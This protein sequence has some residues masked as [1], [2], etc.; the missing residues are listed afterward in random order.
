MARFALGRLVITSNAC[1]L[2]NRIDVSRCLIRH[3][4]GDWGELC[5]EDK[6]ENEFS[7][8]KGFRIL[9]SYRD[10]NSIGF[11]IITE[12]DRSATTILLPDDY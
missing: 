1:G 5:A 3:M 9:S 10:R 2:L 4:N 12:A 11:W 7:L 6:A 8:E